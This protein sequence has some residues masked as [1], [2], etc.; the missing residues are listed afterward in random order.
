ME[1]EGDISLKNVKPG[2]TKNF[3]INIENVGESFSKLSWEISE[4]PTWGTW[5]FFQDEGNNLYPESGFFTI[6]GSV[7]APSEEN[8]EYT[9]ELKIINKNDSN[10]YEIIQVSLVTPKNKQ[11]IRSPLLK[12]LE[13]HPNIFPLIQSLLELN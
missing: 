11:S 2:S 1:S 12:F 5:T 7:I 10:D 4:Y 8:M 6:E 3:N 9:G 13:N